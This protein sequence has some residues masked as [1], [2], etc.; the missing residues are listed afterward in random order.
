MPSATTGTASART[1]SWASAP[2]ACSTWPQ[3]RSTCARSSSSTS[4]ASGT[5]FFLLDNSHLT[6]SAFVALATSLYFA[7]AQSNMHRFVRRAPRSILRPPS[8]SPLSPSAP[9]ALS[10]LPHTLGG[11]HCNTPSALVPLFTFAHFSPTPLSAEVTAKLTMHCYFQELF[12]FVLHF[13]DWRGFNLL[14]ADPTGTSDPYVTM[15][16]KGS[17]WREMSPHNACTHGVAL[18]VCVRA[19]VR[20]RVGW[21]WG[22]GVGTNSV[23]PGNGHRF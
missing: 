7:R 1:I 14:P 4:T 10:L 9:L 13:H 19:C 15:Q 17:V 18:C 2:L 21:G 5:V 22:W 6:G 23:V 11:R 12:P 3:A 16:I 8:P 20:A